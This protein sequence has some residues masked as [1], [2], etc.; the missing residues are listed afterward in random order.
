ML[1]L[2]FSVVG[3]FADNVDLIASRKYRVLF[4]VEMMNLGLPALN[5]Y[6]SRKI[7]KLK[8]LNFGHFKIFDK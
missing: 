3:M 6:T 7:K 1:L 2:Y 5:K 4:Q 8:E